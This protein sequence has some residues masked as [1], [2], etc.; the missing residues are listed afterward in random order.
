MFPLS[1]SFRRALSVLAATLLF[2]SLPVRSVLAA[3][4][5]YTDNWYVPTE[6][7][8]GV[9]FSQT[10][11]FIFA[12]LFIYGTDKKPTWY[13]AQMTWDGSAQFT[14][15]L[16]ATQGSYFGAPWNVAETQPATLVGTAS[17]TPGISNNSS[18]TFSYTVTGVASVTKAVQRL[19]LTS[20]LLAAKYTG[21][22]AGSYSGCSANS[23]N[24]LYQ[25][26]YTLQVTQTGTSV[27]M[28]FAFQSGTLTCTLA[29]ALTQTGSIYSIANASYQC[30]DGLNTNAS[31]ANLRATPLGIE[32]QF[33]APAVGGGC[34]EDARFAAT[35]N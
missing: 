18:G 33:A 11:N 4:Y 27:S 25:D 16:Y 31:V 32:G 34:R 35:L 13:T 14:G 23:S 1:R 6:A 29:G 24:R 26:F 15:G 19:T 8:W 17:F 9:N 2:A 30:S 22:Q 28:S 10:D 12:T 21:G 3:N 7:G 20:V 5:D